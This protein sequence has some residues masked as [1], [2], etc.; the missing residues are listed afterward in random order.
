MI[1][2]NLT[3]Y[4]GPVAKMLI[5]KQ[6]KNT[7]NIHQLINSLVTH[8]PSATDQQN[9]I[10][11]LDFSTHTHSSASLGNHSLLSVNDKFPTPLFSPDYIEQLT[12]D[13]TRYLGPVAKHLMKSMLKKVSSKEELLAC[14]ADKIPNLQERA[15]F[16]KK[17]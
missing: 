3:H 7:D 11:S 2:K 13:L 16:L 5:K 14:L 1:E 6:A 17:K 15:E 8:I 4:L 12:T 9:F 10:S